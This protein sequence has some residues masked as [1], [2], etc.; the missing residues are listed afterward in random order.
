M[1]RATQH[2]RL[3]GGVHFSE[4]FTCKYDN[5]STWPTVGAMFEHHWF[6][7]NAQYLIPTG[8]DYTLNGPL[9][10]MRMHIKRRFYFRERVGVY[11]YRNPNGATPSHH[12]SAVADFGVIYVFR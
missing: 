5:H 11:A 12:V 7:L 2:W 3:G 8:T 6:R 1:L 4:L 9:F 10:D